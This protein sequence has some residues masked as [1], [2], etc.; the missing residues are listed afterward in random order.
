M[1]RTGM[2]GVYSAVKVGGLQVENEILSTYSDSFGIWTSLDLVSRVNN[3][4]CVD[5]CNGY[6]GDEVGFTTTAP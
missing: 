2:F 3:M 4:G 5:H 1:I 6:R